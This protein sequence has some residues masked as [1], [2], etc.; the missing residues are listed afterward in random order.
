MGYAEHFSIANI[1]F[2]VGSDESHEQP[3]PVTRLRDA[4]FFLADLN[5]ESTPEVK[6]ALLQVRSSPG[7]TVK[8]ESRE[9]QP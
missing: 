9:M 6:E 1:P 4:V 7:K 3:M 2:G 8:A 5:L